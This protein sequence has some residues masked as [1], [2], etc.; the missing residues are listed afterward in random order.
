VWSPLRSRGACNGYRRAQRLPKRR[1]SP[2]TSRRATA[3]AERRG[4]GLGS[5]PIEFLPVLSKRCSLSSG[6]K[7]WTVDPVQP[8]CGNH[9]NAAASVVR[10]PRETRFN[11][12]LTNTDC[13]LSVMMPLSL[14]LAV[15]YTECTAASM[16]PTGPARSLRLGKTLLIG[17]LLMS[18]FPLHILNGFRFFPADT[19]FDIFGNIIL[20]KR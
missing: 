11:L 8:V 20:G 16:Y 7:S 4:S 14:F 2:R 12:S 6:Q 1:P 19:G 15:H 10:E 5:I 13:R 17:N 9:R 18:P 3:V